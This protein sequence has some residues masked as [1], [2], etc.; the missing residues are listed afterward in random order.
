[1]PQVDWPDA[2][3]LVRSLVV[4]ITTPFGSGTGFVFANPEET[5]L[6]AIA[7]AAH[8]I[9]HAHAWEQP[10]RIHHL[11]SNAS[12]L[13]RPDNRSIFLE[14]SLDTAAIVLG[15]SAFPFSTPVPGMTPVGKFLKVGNE[16]GWVGFPAVS[17]DNLCFFSGRISCWL[18]GTSAYLV[19]GVAI[20]GVSGG[21]AFH[22]V[23]RNIEVIGV[24]SAYIP[25]R[26]TGEVLPGVCVV[27]DV[28]QLQEIVAAFDNLAEAKQKESPPS[29]V[30]PLDVKEVAPNPSLKQM[31]PG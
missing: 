20:N 23:M 18:G 12:V 22:P 4:K 6:I 19:D 3:E 1:M 10:I 13:A 8:V 17:A 16:I 15:K 28:K 7:T 5:D 25:N 9:D 31:P 29:E 24:L 2:I 26:A 21:P 30:E 27:R 14:E 11:A